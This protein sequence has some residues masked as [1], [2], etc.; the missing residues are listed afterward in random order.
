MAV[1]HGARGDQRPGNRVPKWLHFSLSW[2]S[3]VKPAGGQCD[4]WPVTK[5]KYSRLT[6][7][8][9]AGGRLGRVWFPFFKGIGCPRWLPL[10]PRF[11]AVPEHSVDECTFLT[12]CFLLRV[13]PSP[14]PRWLPLSQPDLSRRSQIG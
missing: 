2:L 12:D 9:E 13:P 5:P 11:L 14:T 8:S 6:A 7:C 3:L 1:V 10:P 4:Q